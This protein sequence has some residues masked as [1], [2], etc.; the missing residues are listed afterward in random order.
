MYLRV[1]KPWEHWPPECACGG[2]YAP[3]LTILHYCADAYQPRGY[4]SFT[5]YSLLFTM[6]KTCL[7][8]FAPLHCYQQGYMQT[9]I[10][11]VPYS[12]VEVKYKPNF[13]CTFH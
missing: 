4:S 7:T 9:N 13:I 2:V 1:T 3:S 10:K 11:H 5:K 8:P 12:G 6:I